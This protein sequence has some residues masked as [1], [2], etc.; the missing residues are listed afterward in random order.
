MPAMGESV[1]LQ[2]RSGGIQP[3]EVDLIQINRVYPVAAHRWCWL[4][5][6]TI[7]TDAIKVLEQEIEAKIKNLPNIFVT[8]T[9]VGWLQLRRR[10]D[11]L[12]MSALMS[13]AVLIFMHRDL[14]GRTF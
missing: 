13:K 11:H 10:F 1:D 14:P 6:G 2:Y 7:K 3:I 5:Y 12:V 4:E 9:N 8:V